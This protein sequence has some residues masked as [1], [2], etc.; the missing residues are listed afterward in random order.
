M[1]LYEYHQSLLNK[2]FYHRSFPDLHYTIDRLDD[3]VS[4]AFNVTWL[5]D[6]VKQECIYT[7]EQLKYHLEDIKCWILVD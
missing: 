1:N 5:E 7:I 3:D 6:G 2:K 4:S